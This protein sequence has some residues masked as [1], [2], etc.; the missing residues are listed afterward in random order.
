MFLLAKRLPLWCLA[1]LIAWMATPGLHAQIDSNAEPNIRL[2]AQAGGTS[3]Q[4]STTP[5]MASASFRS[6]PIANSS[7]PAQPYPYYP[8]YTYDP[9]GGYVSGAA[10]VINAQ[11]QFLVNTQQA[12]L[13]REQV[14]QARIDS[15]RK[16]FDE[17]LYERERRPTLEDERERARVESVRRSRNDPPLTEIWSGKALNDLLLAIQQQQAQG[18]RGPSVPVDEDI[19]RNINVTSGANSGSIGVLRDQGRLHW[20][21]ELARP[22]YEMERRRLD[23][24]AAKAYKQATE[25]AVDAGT[26]QEMSTAVDN[27]QTGL[28]RNVAEASPSDYIKAKRFLS[29]LDSAIRA[30]Q[31]PSISKYATRKLAAKGGTVSDLVTEMSGQ[32]LRFAPAVAGDENAYVALHHALVSYAAPPDS[33]KAWDPLTK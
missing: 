1:G 6:M 30:L 25:G 28:R 18:L 33:Y 3:G 21:L 16:S 20:P 23:D 13:M 14:R 7:Y 5:P 19:L 10:D 11:G 29:D 4:S 22:E 27:L 15:R 12:Y 26:L 2:L 32:G 9:Y 24:F 17:Y 8:G 31:D